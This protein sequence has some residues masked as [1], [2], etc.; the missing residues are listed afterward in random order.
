MRGE[1]LKPASLTALTTEMVLTDGTG[2]GYALGLSVS[3]M[4]NGHRRWAHTGGASGFLSSNVTFPDDKAAI[5]VLTNGEGLAFRSIEAEIET[6]LLA[7]EVDTD[8][9][10]SLERA[11][12]LFAGLQKGSVD[13]SSITDDLN[14]YF[15][16]AV[17]ADF[18]ASLG[19]LGEPTSFTQTSRENRGG[20]VH[21]VFTVNAGGK[22]LRMETY[23]MPDGRFEQCLVRTSAS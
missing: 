18:G 11:R 13:R 12:A 5:T 15:S 6:L 9:E 3:Q 21:R 16:D 4:A 7:G 19:P 20:M 8:A 17:L 2:T 1:I 23:L 14:A 22:V 10:P